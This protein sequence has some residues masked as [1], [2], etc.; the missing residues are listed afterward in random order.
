[1]ATALIRYKVKRKLFGTIPLPSFTK[2]SRV[3]IED[4]LSDQEQVS[5][6]KT[7]LAHRHKTSESNVDIVYHYCPR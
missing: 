3:G 4:K 6:I 5:K 7:R 2:N 1:M